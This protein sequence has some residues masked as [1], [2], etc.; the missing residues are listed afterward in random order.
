M[1]YPTHNV[2]STRLFAQKLDSKQK[3]SYCKLANKA[4]N[5]LKSAFLVNLNSEENTLFN[6]SSREISKF[7]SLTLPNVNS[8][9]NNKVETADFTYTFYSDNICESIGF[10]YAVIDLNKNLKPNSSHLDIIY[11]NFLYD[12]RTLKMEEFPAAFY[13][14]IMCEE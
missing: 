13:K 10:C 8:L 14:S 7:F 12:G 9:N 4:V 6:I 5:E 2:T 11:V 1:P 3:K